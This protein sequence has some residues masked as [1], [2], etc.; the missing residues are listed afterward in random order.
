MQRLPEPAQY[1]L[2]I[3][4]LCPTLDKARWSSIRELIRAFGIR[5]ILAVVPDNQDEWLRAAE[6]DPGF[7]SEIKA[8]EEGGATVALHGYQHRCTSKALSLLPLNDCSEFSGL[9]VA[10]QR[11]K[12]RVGLDILR[13][14]GLAPKLF[15]APNHGFD[16]NTVRA[17]REE[18]MLYIS[19][20]LARIPFVRD[21]VTWLPQQLWSPVLKKRGVWTICLHPNRMT[22]GQIEDLKQFLVNAAAQFTSFE[23][24]IAEYEPAKLPHSE[25]LREKLTLWKLVVRRRRK[26]LWS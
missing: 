14:H 23:R 25:L 3:D 5:P 26:R 7:W 24:L 10:E 12:I 4:D 1:L 20:G 16:R 9:R 13:S 22:F 15:I 17:L 18:G 21:G 8:M 2:R 6:P 11:T 19:D